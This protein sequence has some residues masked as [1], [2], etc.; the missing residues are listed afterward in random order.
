MRPRAF[1]MPSRNHLL[2]LHQESESGLTRAVYLAEPYPDKLKKTAILK[3]GPAISLAKMRYAFEAPV[4]WLLFGT[5]PPKAKPRTG[6]DYDI[7]VHYQ[8]VNY[9]AL[10]RTYGKMRRTFVCPV[11]H[12][13]EEHGKCERHHFGPAP[14]LNDTCPICGGVVVNAKFR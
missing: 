1:M 2:S 7:L 9:I 4:Y 13:R 5:E 12:T 11:E 14:K 6:D 8:G 10:R 3:G